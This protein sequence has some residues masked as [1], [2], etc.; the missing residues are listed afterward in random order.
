MKLTMKALLLTCATLLGAC[1]PVEDSAGPAGSL[2]ALADLATD[3][4]ST[5]CLEVL[6]AAMQWLVHERG[7]Q[8]QEIILDTLASGMATSSARAV[9]ISA[10]HHVGAVAGTSLDDHDSVLDCPADRP[11]WQFPCKLRRGS[12][13]VDLLPPRITDEEAHIGVRVGGENAPAWGLNY[14]ELVF[15]KTVAGSW[16]LTEAKLAGMS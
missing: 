11:R 13:L 16:R 14:Y 5:D 4:C 12:I 2:S 15:R 6:N 10:L 7:Y 8:P 3:T 1:D 9:S